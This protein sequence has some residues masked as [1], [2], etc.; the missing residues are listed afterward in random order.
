V[1]LVLPSE[2]A[3][4]ITTRD[5]AAKIKA[6]SLEAFLVERIAS[7]LLLVLSWTPSCV[8]SAEGKG[9]RYLGDRMV[10][11][12][13]FV[14]MERLVLRTTSTRISGTGTPSG[15]FRGVFFSILGFMVR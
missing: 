14:A 7:R 9:W 5:A 13:Y 12:S 1:P 2:E 3:A 11:A 8:E 10:L 6:R 15:T 4:E